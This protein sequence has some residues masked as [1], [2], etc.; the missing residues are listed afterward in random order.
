MISETAVSCR[1]QFRHQ[2]AQSRRSNHVRGMSASSP[3]PDVSL[4]RSESTRWAIGRLE[5]E[6]LSHPCEVQQSSAD[7]L[8]Y[9]IHLDSAQLNGEE[10]RRPV[11]S[12]FQLNLHKLNG[13]VSNVLDAALLGRHRH[14]VMIL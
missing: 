12:L 6:E 3:T 7:V 5:I 11:M 13:T 2:V 4:R 8:D 9:S 10:F 14:E 1:L